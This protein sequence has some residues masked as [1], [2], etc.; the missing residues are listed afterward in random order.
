MFRF[1]Y[2]FIYFVT[3]A[4][5][6]IGVDVI[7][8]APSHFNRGEYYE[9]QFFKPLISSCKKNNIS[10]LILEEPSKGQHSRNNK[11]IPFDFIFLLIIILRKWMKVEN[12][13]IATEN[14]IGVLLSNTLFRNFRYKNYIVLSKS[15]I[16]V[17]ST[18]NKEAKLFDLQHGIIF[19]N[20]S[21]YFSNNILSPHLERNNV[22][23]LLSGSKF[24]ELLVK[25]G[26]SNFV[27]NNA[28]VIGVEVENKFL[29][30]EANKHVLVTLQF[31]E[32]HTNS[33]NKKLLEELEF[34]I[35]ENRDLI[36]YL[37]NHPRFNNEVDLTRL[38]EFENVQRANSDLYSNFPKCS[39]HLT[40]YSTTTFECALLGIPTVFMQCLSDEFSMFK[41]DYDYPFNYSL[42]EVLNNYINCSNKVNNWAKSYYSDFNEDKFIKCLAL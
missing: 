28:H 11:S 30:K 31:T 27:E 1:I 2:S 19:T 39:L 32:D 41:K 9:N 12:D 29:H 15:M 17:F 7:F 10:Y 14:K 38:Y 34:V 37:R 24:K 22:S 18:I 4:F 40:A 36:F 25:N 16:S 21:D 35:D 3:L 6:K 23:L 13:I 8:Y 20:K 5:R 26:E 42:V 33:Q